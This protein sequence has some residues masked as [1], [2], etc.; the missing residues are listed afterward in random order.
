MFVFLILFGV[1]SVYFYSSLNFYEFSG[2]STDL[3]F[4]TSSYWSLTGFLWLCD[5]KLIFCDHCCVD[6]IRESGHLF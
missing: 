1:L 2:Q 6:S 5:V 3:Y 4:V